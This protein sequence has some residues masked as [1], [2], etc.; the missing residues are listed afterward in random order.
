MR[1]PIST[2]LVAA[3]RPSPQ[4]NCFGARS[5]RLRRSS[6]GRIW[7][8]TSS[9]AKSHKFAV[10]RWRTRVFGRYHT[11]R[12]RYAMTLVSCALGL[13]V[14]L[15]PVTKHIQGNSIISY[16]T[17]RV[18]ARATSVLQLANPRYSTHKR[19]SKERP[20]SLP[21]SRQSIAKAQGR[22]SRPP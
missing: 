19:R 13:G 15:V 17:R 21:H 12:D 18:F 10:A 8:L 14:L 16:Q 4:A 5:I 6:K 9:N 11:R 22:A 2:Q 7:Q 20:L 3:R 1:P